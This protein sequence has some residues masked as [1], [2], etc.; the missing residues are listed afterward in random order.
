MRF[1]RA[2]N[3]IGECL[4]GDW[5]CY[6]TTMF[7]FY[8][9]DPDWPGRKLSENERRALSVAQKAKKVESATQ[10]AVNKLF[11]AFNPCMRFIPYVS[12]HEVEA[13]LF[14]DAEKLAA[15]LD[16]KRSAIDK[17]LEACGEPENINDSEQTAPS[18]R[19]LALDHRFKK[20]NK[21]VS[22]ATDIGLPA[23]RG[24]CPHFDGWVRKLEALRPLGC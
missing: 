23:M 16:V 14:S 7:D 18:K 8:G 1:A 22:L 2:K 10:E 20:I 5:D 3:S 4:K 21:G 9:I 19:L 6:V 12:M 13:L 24:K 15:K 11:G 17:I